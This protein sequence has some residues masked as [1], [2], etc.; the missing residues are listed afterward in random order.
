V[1]FRENLPIVLA[2]GAIGL[3]IAQS[4]HPFG[5]RVPPGVLI[6]VALLSVLRYVLR[7]QLQKGNRMLK[8][9]P[10]HPLGISDPPEK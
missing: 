8:D 5:N 3:A 9:V 2:V 1:N 4:I 10:E 7:R 6:V